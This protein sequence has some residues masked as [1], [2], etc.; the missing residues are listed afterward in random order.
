[1]HLELSAIFNE[2]EIVVCKHFRFGRVKFFVW[3]RLKRPHH[4]FPFVTA[5]YTLW[6]TRHLV[7]LSNPTPEPV[8]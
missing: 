5:R 1:M 8:L 2:F 4:R 7:V 6:C 3:E